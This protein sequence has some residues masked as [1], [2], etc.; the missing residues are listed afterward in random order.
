M[1]SRWRVHNSLMDT[2]RGMLMVWGWQRNSMLGCSILFWIKLLTGLWWIGSGCR[3]CSREN[4]TSKPR[5]WSGTSSSAWLATPTST[6]TVPKANPF[7]RSFYENPSTSST[8]NFHRQTNSHPTPTTNPCPWS[9][10]SH[11]TSNPSR[12][13]NPTHT[14][15]I[16]SK[17]LS[18]YVITLWKT[19]RL[20]YRL[21]TSS[22]GLWLGSQ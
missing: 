6:T 4:G 20:C 14:L 9:N 7:Y 12:T 21:T 16:S 5:N 15:T 18:S 1:L 17:T 19:M 13:S 3:C 2:C 10:P 8:A 11:S 22:M